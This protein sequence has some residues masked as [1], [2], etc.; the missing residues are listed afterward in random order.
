MKFQHV[1]KFTFK[2]DV[3]DQNI[4][5]DIILKISFFLFAI[6]LS[7]APLKV[8][9]E[10]IFYSPPNY[11]RIASEIRSKTGI[12]LA[13]RY[14]MDLIGT[15]GGF[16]K[17]VNMLAL[18]FNIKGP[19][20]KD[21]LRFI[22]VDCVETFLKEINDNIEIRPFL[23]NYP[24]TN[25]E[26]KIVLFVKDQKG[27][28]IVDPYIAV[29]SNLEGLIYFKIMQKD[30]PIRYKNIESEPYLESLNIVQQSKHVH[31][32]SHIHESCGQDS[33]MSTICINC[34]IMNKNY[35]PVNKPITI[36]L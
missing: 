7:F 8:M 33:I 15:G 12:I 29:C 3:R 26:I 30:N 27:Y 6:F 5:I 34:S 17:Q 14:N 21:R 36:N 13:N 23:K 10:N 35:Q 32:F 19:L 31:M 18:M 4:G 20:S 24:F 25:K 9:K 11:I 28:E 2:L 16:V 22:L 1:K